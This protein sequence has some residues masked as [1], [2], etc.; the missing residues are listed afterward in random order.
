MSFNSQRVLHYKGMVDGKRGCTA[1]TP[2]RWEV[3]NGSN[4]NEHV[5]INR[6][7]FGL[8][9]VNSHYMEPRAGFGPATPALPN[10]L[11]ARFCGDFRQYLE[12]FQYL[13]V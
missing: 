5:G 11:N 4:G 13:F 3:N 2:S 7:D 9:G 1:S 10:E 12:R 8:F 6:S